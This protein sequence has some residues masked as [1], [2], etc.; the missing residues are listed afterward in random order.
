VNRELADTKQRLAALRAP[1]AGNAGDVDAAPA[2]AA[3]IARRKIASIRGASTNTSTSPALTAS[4]RD[5]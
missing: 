4:A 3:E 1:D 2:Q 5:G